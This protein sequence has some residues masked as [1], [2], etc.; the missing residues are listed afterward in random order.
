M[1]RIAAVE[2]APTADTSRDLVSVTST[3]EER[4]KKM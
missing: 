4:Q 3:H 2:I 1:I